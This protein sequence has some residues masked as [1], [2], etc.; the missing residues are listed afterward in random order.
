MSALVEQLRQAADRIEALEAALQEIVQYHVKAVA[1]C[2]ALGTIQRDDH[3][4]TQAIVHDIAAEDIREIIRAALDKDT[5][6]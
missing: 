5:T 6:K 4:R 2:S 3:G 1:A